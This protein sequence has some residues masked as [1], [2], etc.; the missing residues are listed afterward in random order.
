MERTN[1][2]IIFF[3]LLLTILRIS[4]QAPVDFSLSQEVKG[5]LPDKSYSYYRL[6][7][8]DIKTNTSKFLLIE[9][10]R[11][12]EQDLIDN[13][14]SNPNLYISTTNLYPSPSSNTW[15]SNRFGDEIISIDQKYVKS[16][17]FF[18]MSVYCDFKCNY[19]L[20]AKL[21]EN[22]QLKEDKLYTLSMIKDDVL[23]ITFKTRKKFEQVKI[24]CV[25]Y[26]MKP[27]QIFLAKKDPSSSN[28]LPSYPIFLNGYYFTIR[29]GDQNY[30]TQQEYEVLLE[31]KEF[32]QDLLFWIIYDNEDTEISELSPVFGSASSDY[33]NC[34]SFNIDKQHLDKDIIISTSLFNGNGYIRIGGWKKVKKMKVKTVDKNTYPVISDKSILLTKK[35]FKDYGETK[36]NKK[37]DLHFCFI[38]TEETSF[39]LKIYY[40][41]HTEQAQRLNYLL[42]G[43]GLD[44]MLP[45]NSVTKYAIL[46]F[47][48]NKDIN[49]Q[50]KV[51]NGR[52]KLYLYYTFEEN[53]YI[54]KTLLD[55]MKK[56]DEIIS[57]TRENYQK[58]KIEVPY[59]DN[60]CILFPRFPDKDQKECLIFA[61]VDCEKD[62]DCLYELFFDHIGSVINMKPKVIYS[63]VITEREIDK[64]EIHIIDDIEENLAIIL[65]QDTGTT[66]LKLTKFISNNNE[67][68]FEDTEKFNKNYMPN[69][70]EIKSSDFPNNSI[71]GKFFIEVIGYSFSSYSIYY[72]T[73]DSSSSSKLDH[74]IISMNL[75][76]GN[77]IQDYIKDNH[78]IKVYN[79]DNSNI[80]NKKTDLFIYF[81]GSGYIDYQLFIFKNLEDYSYEKGK[82]EGFVWESDYSN[83]IHISKEDPK[84]IIGN[85]YIMVFVLKSDDS[86]SNQNFVYRKENPSDF[87]FLLVITDETT[88]ITLLE[89]VEFR[90][91]FTDKRT[92]QSFY[93]NHRNRD[94]DFLLSINVPLSKIKIGLKIGDKDFIYE[95]IIKEN[96]FLRVE[97][98]D[99]YEYCPSSKSCNIEIKIESVEKFFLELDVILLCKS[100]LNSIVYLNKNSL[101]EKRKISNNEKQYF[102]VEANPSKGDI[103]RIN[104]I[105]TYGRGIIYVKK[106][107][108]NLQIEQMNFP[109]EEN[110][111]YTSNLNN[112][113]ELS[114]VNIPYEDIQNDLPCKLLVTVIGKFDYLGQSQGEYS[115]SLSNIVDDI[116]PNK[117]YRLFISKGEIKYFYFIIKGSKKRLS[118]SMTNKE[119]DAYMYL[120]YESMNKEISDFEWK[121]EGIYNEYIDISVED[122]YFISRKM[123]NLDGEYYLAIRGFKDTYYNLFISD[124]NTKI[125]TISEEFPGTCAC[126]KGDYCYFRYEN[127]FSPEIAEVHEQELIFYFEFTYGEAN[128]YASLFETGNNEVILN[129]LPT[130]YKKDYQ[131]IFS[132]QYLRI[133]LTPG[134]P[135]YTLDSVLV[136]GTR[137]KSKSMFDFNVRP[138]WKSG[139]I[140]K[141][142][143]GYA[144]LSMDSD[145]IFYISQNSIKPINL[146][147]YSYTNL[148][149]SYEVRAISGSAQVHS[150]VFNDE[151]SL[152]DEFTINKIKGYKHLSEFS[153]DENESKSHF[154]SISKENSFRQN[155]YFEVK[156]KRDCLF[157]IYIHHNQDALLIPMSNEIQ[158]KFNE[159]KFY[160]YIELLPEYEEVIFNVDKMHSQSQFSIY[161]KTSILNSLNFKS[162]L[163]YSSP[164]YNNFD[165]K[166]RTNN[167]NTLS[168]KIKNLPKEIFQKGKKVITMLYIQ[169]ENEMT[170]NDK[171]NMIAYPNVDHYERITP[172]PKKYIYSSLSNKKV[173]T[174]V[175]SFKQQE[176]KDNLLII[177]ISTCRGNLG[178]KITDSLSND[179]TRNNLVKSF[180]MDGKGKKVVFARIEKN[181]EYF[182]SVYGLKEDE[183]LFRDFDIKTEDIDFLLYYYTTDEYGYSL[184]QFDSKLTY[185][186]KGPG[187]LVLKLPNLGNINDK[188]GKIKLEDI[189][190]SLIITQNKNEFDYM[191]SICY[192][193]KKMEYIEQQK[194]Y[195]NYTININKNKNE[196]ENNNLDKNQNYYMNV[197]ITNKKTGQIFALEPLQLKPNKIVVVFGNNFIIL[198]LLKGIIILICFIFY[199]YRK[200]RITKAIVNYESN[201]IKN[202]GSI[203]KSI[204]ELKKI[205]E[206]KNK[207]AKKKYNSLTEDSGQ[208]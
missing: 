29:K 7:I 200:Y 33:P 195:A 145:N 126:E 87:P 191:D 123:N 177:E 19:I 14:F 66:K 73:F 175:F 142:Y 167:F 198:L 180:V 108:K 189:N 115:I 187:N 61:V 50:L 139:E 98:K 74:K 13:V 52:P 88:P 111:Q 53:S 20:D 179:R 190:V 15:S 83:Y 107:E 105:F 77:I 166:A 104:A 1:F 96:Y 193:S 49:I 54:N 153:I 102:V 168:I 121:S 86:E 119:V 204:T 161:A 176:K 148:P 58:Y 55:E 51:K 60:K 62:K 203:P 85:L 76:K 28:S 173:D 12:V 207:E 16:G 171:L 101:I 103:V 122:P 149:I 75:I 2:F 11:N 181:V 127:I 196:I 31:N 162:M 134:T 21:Y 185:D 164:S 100:S 112:I 152:N 169:A 10:R 84:Y 158:G 131:S 42:P 147:L 45:G 3:I 170:F 65:N 46:Y 120:N 64:Y 81:D 197:L 8:P 182:L 160:A 174:T 32:K 109:S 208:I 156:A 125:M 39:L 194:L 25:S 72:Y 91:T 143:E 94:E 117:N 30:A 136:L 205:Q 129:Y 110:Y 163:S 63:N 133:K 18:Y 114:I 41:E 135:K 38:A 23:K 137:C 146:T 130:Q 95:K 70:I 140:L 157:S 67:I 44:D 116:F 4:N 172:P 6:K 36:K 69:V 183:M 178:Y 26:K 90:Q 71:K 199:F 59:I 37:R 186:L 47:E 144:Y 9:A 106:A 78:N 27:F 138:L 165:I 132:N 35:N 151:E 93:Y 99:I 150:Y 43:I 22:Y 154:N 40:K 17:V 184:T 34:Y 24:S 113:E 141:D 202:M 56:K 68:N 89:G 159:G 5:S 188:N 128:I 155:V 124:S 82:V 118:V 97:K 57:S 92:Y 192:L 79:Y 80:G 48:Q 206:E 201:D